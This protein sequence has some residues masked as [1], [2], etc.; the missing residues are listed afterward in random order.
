DFLHFDGLDAMT[1]TSHH[2][3]D[4]D[5][6]YGRLVDLVVTI[7][8][9]AVDMMRQKFKKVVVVQ[10]E[11]NHDIAG[12]VWLRKFLKHLYKNDKRVEVIDNEYPYYAYLHGDVLIGFHHGHKAKKVNLQKIFSSEPRIRPL[13]GA[14]TYC[15]IH[16]GHQHHEHKLE[17]AGAIV[18]QHPTLAARDSYATRLGLVSNRGAKLH[19]YHK[20]KGETEVHTVRP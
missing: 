6:R 13:W 9:E 1:P 8:P 17:D 14:S 12:S 19:V 2:L 4:S 16:T 3:L 15:Y 7:M 10:A 11:G 18:E 5:T 20:Q